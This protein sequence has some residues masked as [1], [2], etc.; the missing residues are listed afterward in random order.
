[1]DD[2]A[3]AYESFSNLP[4]S[5]TPTATG[6]QI[7][8]REALT[9]IITRKDASLIGGGI[10]GLTATVAELNTLDVSAE[11]ETIAEGD[12]VDP[13][14]RFTKIAATALGTISLAAPPSSMY[15][16]FKMIESTSAQEITMSLSNVAV[17]GLATTNIVF[18][19]IDQVL[20]LQA[21]TNKWYEV[22]TIGAVII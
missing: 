19:A 10:P 12:I 6:D 8:V 11:T 2:F 18:S 4:E 5:T 7:P 9:G 15:G 3:L 1:M 13:T 21:G 14:K 20:I 22:A 17:Q 16:Q